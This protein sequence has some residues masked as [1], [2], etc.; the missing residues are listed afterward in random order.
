MS[1]TCCDIYKRKNYFISKQP[2]C[3]GLFVMV[4]SVNYSLA[5]EEKWPTSSV[6]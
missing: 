3:A 2:A 4:V 1:F 5:V 6:S